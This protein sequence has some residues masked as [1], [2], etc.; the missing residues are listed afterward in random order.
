[1]VIVNLWL[2]PMQLKYYTKLTKYFTMHWSVLSLCLTEN[3][4]ITSFENAYQNMDKGTFLCSFFI[5]HASLCPHLQSLSPCHVVN[6]FFYIFMFKYC[7]HI[8]T[9]T[10][11]YT[12]AYVFLNT[13]SLNVS[14]LSL[15]L[16]FTHFIVL[17][18]GHYSSVKLMEFFSGKFWDHYKREAALKREKNHSGIR[19]LKDFLF[20]F[21]FSFLHKVTL[22]NIF[23]YNYF[24]TT[25]FFKIFIFNVQMYIKYVNRMSQMSKKKKKKRKDLFPIFQTLGSLAMSGGNHLTMTDHTPDV[26]AW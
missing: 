6:Y 3:Y 11:T 4:G 16:F 15:F 23:K 8:D 9:H 7:V 12:H 17:N 14:S 22:I 24:T 26:T 2:F 20:L 1:M 19:L 25:W 13:L 10:H 18:I 5:I 21:F